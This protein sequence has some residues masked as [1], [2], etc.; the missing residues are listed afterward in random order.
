MTKLVMNTCK[1]ISNICYLVL[2]A[3]LSANFTGDKFRK[4]QHHSASY[5]VLL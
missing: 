3:G 4:V 1:L 5:I 2:G